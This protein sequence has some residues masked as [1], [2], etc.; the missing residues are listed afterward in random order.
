MYSF[1]REARM[2]DWYR[3]LVSSSNM[4]LS[5][6]QLV[7][8]PSSLVLTITGPRLAHRDPMQSGNSAAGGHYC[9][10]YPAIMATPTASVRP[11]IQTPHQD[12]GTHSISHCDKLQSNSTTG[13]ANASTTAPNGASISIDDF[14]K[15]R[16]ELSTGLK[17]EAMARLARH[18]C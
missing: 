3:R 9:S 5:L 10:R 17:L 16:V 2:H 14:V 18:C 7:V 13:T 4:L 1:V 12:N 8:I 11:T 15:L 6:V